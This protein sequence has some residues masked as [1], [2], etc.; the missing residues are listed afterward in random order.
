[1]GFIVNWYVVGVLLFFLA[2][3]IGIL[4]YRFKAGKGP[5][6][7]TEARRTPKHRAKRKRSK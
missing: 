2:V 5:M 7:I 4:V 3:I 6:V 1:M